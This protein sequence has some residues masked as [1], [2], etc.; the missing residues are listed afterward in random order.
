V[1]PVVAAYFALGDTKTPV[2]VGAIC[3]VVNVGLGAALM[4]PLAHSGLALASS[5]SSWVNFL[6]LAKFLNRRLGNNWVRIGRTTW[7]SLGLSLIIGAAS[8]AL[9]GHGAWSLV[10]IIPLAA[11]YMALA[12]VLH[13][14]EAVMLGDFI[15]KR[16]SGKF[17][18]KKSQPGS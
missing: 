15:G 4:F 10:L 8:Y 16:L 11:V 9:S 7:V 3:L 18:P 12:Y 14:E 2:W 5:I 6:L 17:F 1:R 13:V